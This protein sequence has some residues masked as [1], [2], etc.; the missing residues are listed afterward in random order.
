[1]LETLS[2]GGESIKPFF[3]A[4]LDSAALKSLS[5]FSLL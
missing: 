2:L 1:M 4:W 3:R 5:L